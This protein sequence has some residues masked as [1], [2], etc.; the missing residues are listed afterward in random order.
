MT[1]AERR[2][3][4]RAGTGLCD[5]VR[6]HCAAIAATAR[7]VTIDLEA[8]DALGAPGDAPRATLDPQ[9]HHLDGSPEEVARS[10]LTLDAINFGSG[11]F[12]TLRKRPGCSGYVTIA[13]ALRERFRSRGP[14]TNAQLQLL[15]SATVAAT[16]GQPPDHELMSL[17]AQAMSDA[18]IGSSAVTT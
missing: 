1:D 15:D 16:L 14:W 8:L 9:V 18:V 5:E 12:P 10:L 11:W 6:A 13:S 4:T 17:Y 7:S 3:V 2:A